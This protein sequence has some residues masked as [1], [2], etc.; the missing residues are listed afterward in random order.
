MLGGL[1][2][3]LVLV[4]GGVFSSCSSSGR[5]ERY[6]CS[7]NTENRRPSGR[8]PPAGV[9][10]RPVAPPR[11]T[12]TATAIVLLTAFVFLLSRHQAV[13][14][15]EVCGIIEES[16]T[17]KRLRLSVHPD[18]NF[19]IQ[20]VSDQGLMFVGFLQ[21]PGGG[22]CFLG[23]WD[24][25]D[26]SSLHSSPSPIHR[27]AFSSGSSPSDP[28]RGP[29]EPENRRPGSPAPDDPTRPMTASPRDPCRADLQADGGGLRRHICGD[30]M[31]TGRRRTERPELPDATGTY[32]D[33]P[34]LELGGEP[35]SSSRFYSLRVPLFVQREAG[36]TT[37][38]DAHWL[39]HMT[40]HFT[41]GARLI[42]GFF[43][44]ADDG[45]D[46]GISSVD[47]V[48]IFRSSD[49]ET[50]ATSYDAIVVEQWTVVDGVVVRTDY[51]PL[52]QSL[53]PYGWRL[54][55][56]LPT[57]V[58]RT[59]SDGSLSTKQIL[60]L[61]RPTLQRKRKD[62]K[63][64]TLRGRGKA[65]KNYSSETPEK[66]RAESA[67]PVSESEVDELLRT[68]KEEEEEEAEEDE[69]EDEEEEE[70]ME[71]GEERMEERMKSA[72][73]WGGQ[74]AITRGAEHQTE[75][76]QPAPE[77]E[78]N[79]GVSDGNRGDEADGSPAAEREESGRW[80]DDVCHGEAPGEETKAQDRIKPRLSER[81]L[82]SGVC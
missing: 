66:E 40:Q 59:N 65:R 71:K 18:F 9:R 56:V 35:D 30:V 70:V 24:P 43:H 68:T 37:E 60:F 57:P 3:P 13:Y 20:D 1:S 2:V 34:L 29:G 73:T 21:Q 10:L 5:D 8:P 17:V 62:F 38:V 72:G 44:L 64:L 79:G 22:P 31:K 69:G 78:R 11:A 82:F 81:A 12:A 75:P 19:K 4:F 23:P 15:A 27:H 80:T 58:V 33:S 63:M 14:P 16:E 67:S 51:V 26:L 47:G 61:Q 49:E 48:F 28:P 52:L 41:S 53:A 54:M 39:D 42:D 32:P 50:S 74:E 76:S 6:V 46:S 77:E 36:L 45:G 55:C 25:E 7:E